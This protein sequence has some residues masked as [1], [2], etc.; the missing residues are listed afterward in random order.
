MRLIVGLGNPGQKYQN[1]RH[2]VGF[3]VVDALAS[4][5][6]SGKWVVNRKLQSTLYTIHQSLVLAK[7]QTYMNSTGT[8]VSKIVKQ[9]KLKLPDVWVVHDDLDLRLGEYKIQFGIGP[10]VH[11]GLLSIYEKL[12]TKDFWH[13]RI[14]V[15]NREKMEN[16]KWKM[17]NFTKGEQYVLQD[18]TKEEFNQI[19]ET[20]QRVVNELL[21]RLFKHEKV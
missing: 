17:E 18:F 12:G 5:V 3:V 20:N 1:N 4:K 2:N 7:P 15:D 19:N 13:V 9:F 14:G 16:G 21:N 8:A 10:K 11:H 6:E